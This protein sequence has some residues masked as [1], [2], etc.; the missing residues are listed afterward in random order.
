MDNRPIGVFDSGLGGLTVVKKL[1]E[2]LPGED[3]VY[4]GDTQRVPYGGRS[5]QTLLKYVTQDIRFLLSHDVK[6]I[7]AACGTASAVALPHLTDT[8]DLPVLGVLEEAAKSALSKTK[9]GKIGVIATSATVKSDA[10]KNVIQ[11][12]SPETQVY[13]KACP[14]FVPLVENGHL[15]SEVAHLVAEEYLE[16]VQDSG[17]DALIMG[18]THYPLLRNTIADVLGDGVSLI[19]V[20]EAMAKR[21][22]GL[23]SEM[24]IASDKQTGGSC[25]YFVSDEV[26][27]FE[28]LGGLFLQS[29]IEG[30]VSKIDIDKY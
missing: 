22:K 20:G 24:D 17:A 29:K 11:S 2:M 27:N 30:M 4:F 6:M 23:L 25:R 26:D 7:V 21:V 18:C 14:L 12:I 9:C 5:K 19:D 10:Y 15:D 28:A 8:F 1:R 16:D 3:I 13:S